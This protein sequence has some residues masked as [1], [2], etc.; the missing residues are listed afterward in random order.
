MGIQSLCNNDVFADVFLKHSK[1]LYRF[2][3]I[4]Y[5]SVDNKEDYVQEAFTTLWENC[6]KVN[7]RNVKSYLETVA[8]NKIIEDWR[9]QKVISKHQ[10]DSKN[11]PT[12]EEKDQ[13]RMAKKEKETQLKKC[14][15]ELPEKQRMALELKFKKWTYQE[16]AEYEGISIRGVE[17][18]VSEAMRKLKEC[19]K[20]RKI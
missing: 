6:A 18:R 7:I 13:D 14:L 20:N 11:K 8:K 15:Q 10:E 1:G 17:R 16:I 4:K 19:L 9:K 2:L 3:C 5:N 12:N